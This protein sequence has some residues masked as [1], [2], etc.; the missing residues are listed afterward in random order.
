[1]T[2][3]LTI[4]G[5]P[6][7]T[8]NTFDV[9]NPA[10]E[11]VVAACPL[12]TVSEVDAAVAA[13]RAAFPGWV[14]TPDADR[15]AALNKIADLIEANAAELSRIITEE[16]GKPQAGP[17]A[18]FEVEGAVGW[19]R[20]TAGLSL[21]PQVLIDTDEERVEVHREPVGVVASI[22]PWNWPLMIAIWHIMP[23]IRIGCTV[24]IKPSPYTPLSTL[25]LVALI[26]EAGILPAGVLNAVTGDAEVGDRISSHPD[27]DKITFTG[28]IPTGRRIMERAGDTLKK[29]TLELGGNDAGIVLPGTDISKLIEPLF[30][31]TFIN[32][33]QTCSCLKRLY[34]H[35]DDVETVGKALADFV[36]NIPVGNGMDE[37][38]LIGPLSNAMQYNKVAGMVE[39]AKAKG[40][41]VLAGGEPLEGPGFV[42]PLTV[43]SGCNADMDVV[44]DEQFGTVVPIIAY[45]TVDEAVTA[46]NSLEVGLGASVWGNDTAEAAEVAKRLQAGTRWVNRHAV[47]NP[48]VP[49]GGV[50]QSGIGVEFSEEGLREYTTVQVLSIAK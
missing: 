28:S 22:T 48:M 30:W 43:L 19:T 32:A 40:A 25:K 17:G 37:G 26:N 8:A 41:T 39:D 45:K 42:Y 21:T 1:M 7:T 23:A 29:L 12:G 35:E 20:V 9:I 4:G 14:A 46:A 13:A 6:A 18:N 38:I 27:I 11:A 5:K 15:A 47:L 33:G 31:G 50:K 34:V 24:V 10:T 3:N 2:Y 36:A 16:Q 49:M 44:R